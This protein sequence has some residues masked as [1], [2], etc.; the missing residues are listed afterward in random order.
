MR[1]IKQKH[2][3]VNFR[4]QRWI[5]HEK[6]TSFMSKKNVYGYGLF[7]VVYN[8]PISFFSAHCQLN[9]SAA[10]PQNQAAH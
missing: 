4:V 8:M 1:M 9:K 6:I 10:Y 2:I 7:I 3:I 5:F